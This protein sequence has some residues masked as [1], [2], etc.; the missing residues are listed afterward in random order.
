MPLGGVGADKQDTRK[1][2][3]VWNFST[4]WKGLMRY[5]HRS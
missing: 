4:Y 5:L 2:I 3:R 1:D